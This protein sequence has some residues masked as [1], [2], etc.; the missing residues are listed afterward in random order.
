MKGADLASRDSPKNTPVEAARV[1]TAS[2]FF[3]SACIHGMWKFPG[4]GRNLS[5]SCSRARSLTSCCGT[6]GA[7]CCLLMI[8]FPSNVTFVVGNG[9]THSH[10][11][12]CFETR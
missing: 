11:F 5:H 1:F 8:A 3:F 9:E 12:I 6:A 2:F 10:V 7:P 4:Q